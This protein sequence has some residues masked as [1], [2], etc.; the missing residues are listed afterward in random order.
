MRSI[1][2]RLVLATVACSLIIF[3]PSVAPAEETDTVIATGIGKDIEAAIKNAAENALTQIVGSFVD[4]NKRVERVKEI[5]GAVKNETKKITSS[6]SEYSQGTVQKIKV[7]D[8]SE[9][10]GII[11][12]TAQVTVRIKAFQNYIKETAL[13][14]AKV[15]DDMFSKVQVEKKQSA[16]LSQ[17]VIDRVL[18]DARSLSVLN[19]AATVVE[20]PEDL[21]GWA[22]QKLQARDTD[23]LVGV[24]VE[25]NYKDDFLQNTKDTFEKTANRVFR[26]RDIHNGFM[27]NLQ[28]KSFWVLVGDLEDDGEDNDKNRMSSLVVMERKKISPDAMLYQFEKAEPL[29]R[30]AKPWHRESYD[31]KKNRL[32]SLVIDVLDASGKKIL[33]EYISDLG[34]YNHNMTTANALVVNR[35]SLK[36]F[37]YQESADSCFSMVDTKITFGV[38]I[39][40]TDEQL[41]RAKSIKI[42][43]SPADGK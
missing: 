31:D 8:T 27:S 29:C 13:G 35:Y 9:D 15:D 16:G 24:R 14:E 43:L 17:I 37:A 36:P 2:I 23:S 28:R 3:L 38:I 20:V 39:K 11:R 7:L 6:V 25:A 5:S 19:V 42:A 12:V 21:K 18:A 41:K 10:N 30:A 1:N 40:M 34:D 26:G 4:S 33:N 22:A 32:P